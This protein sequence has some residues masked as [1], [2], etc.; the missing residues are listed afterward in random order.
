MILIDS[1]VCSKNA[2]AN[3]GRKKRDQRVSTINELKYTKEEQHISGQ[4]LCYTRGA[5]VV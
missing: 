1:V 5:K 2:K 4:R 3:I